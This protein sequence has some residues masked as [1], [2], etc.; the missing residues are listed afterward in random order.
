MSA[1]MTVYIVDDD[2]SSISS[3]EFLLK[4]V[5]YS[6]TSYYSPEQFL[7]DYNYDEKNMACLISDIRM[8]GMTGLELQEILKKQGSSIPVI[9]ITGY[10]DIPIAI[11]AIRQGAVDFLEKPVNGQRLLEAINQCVQEQV[12]IKTRRDTSS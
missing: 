8:P 10:A 2:R 7:R 5:K 12:A 9:F 6:V 11:R 1:N 4:S 3:L